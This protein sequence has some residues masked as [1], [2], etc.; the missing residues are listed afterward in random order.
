MKMFERLPNACEPCGTVQF[1]WTV[2]NVGFGQAKFYLDKK[3]GYV[4]CS[5]EGM[6]R[7]FIKKI[8]CEMVDNAVMDLPHVN[9]KESKG[10]PKD[11]VAKPIVDND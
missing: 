9:E 6:S 4:H 3:D 5:N 7:E 1:N 8:L 2:K 10:F 11:Y